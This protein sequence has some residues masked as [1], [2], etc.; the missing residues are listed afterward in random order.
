MT[1]E[2]DSRIWNDLVINGVHIEQ[3]LNESLIHDIG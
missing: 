2:D 3:I 1:F